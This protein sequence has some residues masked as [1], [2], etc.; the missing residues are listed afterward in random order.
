ML[1]HPPREQEW[2]SWT[3]VGLWTLIIYLTIP[4]ARAIQ[5]FVYLNWGRETFAYV[6][7]GIVALASAAGVIHFRRSRMSLASY[8]WLLV[9]S[10]IFVKYTMALRS[11]EE[12]LHFVEY[13]LLG[14]LA[15]RALCHRIRDVSIYFIAA[16]LCTIAGTIDELIQWATPGRYWGLGDIWLNGFAGTLTLV[17]IAK[18]LRP[19][20][21][22]K[23]VSVTSVRWLCRASGVALI[24]LLISLLNTPARIAR[25]TDRFPFLAYL[26]NQE[27]MMF[28]Y[29]Y[30]YDDPETGLFRSRLSSEELW[31]IDS[32]R[33]LEAA[34]ILDRS[35]DKSAYRPF[36]RKYSPITDPFLHEA[37]VH[38]FRRDTYLLNSEKHADDHDKYRTHLTVAYRENQILEK[39][40]KNT[41]RHSSYVLTPDQLATLE[42]NQLPDTKYESPVS[43]DLVTGVREWQVVGGLLFAI[44][45]L[46]VVDLRMSGR[47]R[48]GVKASEG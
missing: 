33:G 15:Y 6:V 23:G 40:F 28:E 46:A 14:F 36:L 19:S 29:G 27:S 16:I 41:L 31:R 2:V 1:N 26:K 12:A 8:V 11:P 25:Y 37:R 5:K 48:T 30:L 34:G 43:R 3:I 13:G 18:G 20:L 47:E 21:I 44:L 42:Q 39:H 45:G 9:I 35:R 7:I 4:F 17:A 24:L 38:L 32:D 10:G 22:S